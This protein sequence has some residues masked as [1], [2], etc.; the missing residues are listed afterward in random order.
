MA[1]MLLIFF[2]TKDNIYKFRL[3]LFYRLPP[4]RPW[5]T[6]VQGVFPTTVKWEGKMITNGKQ[7]RIQEVV[8]SHSKE[9]FSNSMKRVRKVKNCYVS[10]S[11]IECYSYPPAQYACVCVCVC[12]CVWGV[13]SHNAPDSSW[14]P[15]VPRL[16]L[17]G[18][19]QT[20][21]LKSS[22]RSI[23]HNFVFYIWSHSLL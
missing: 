18:D 11:P 20:L 8:M 4:A 12:E 21:S 13:W 7:I 3:F 23:K 2:I 10:D 14:V 17:G 16:R 5:F 15:P 6:S 1:H 22:W 19:T 9:I